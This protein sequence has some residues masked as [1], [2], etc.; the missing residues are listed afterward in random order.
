MYLLVYLVTTLSYSLHLKR[1]VL[2]DVVLL[3][4]LYTLRLLAGGAATSVG[5]SPWLGGFSV[6]LFLS[7]A[8]VKRFSELQDIK[9]AG[10]V[11]SN[12]RGYLLSDSEQMRSFGTSSAYASIVVFSLYI[13][14]GDVARLYS[15][16]QRLWLMTPIMILWL[17]RVWLLAS[18]G[19]LDE[20]P[21]IFALTDR[22]SMLLGLV[23]V[24]VILL[25]AA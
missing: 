16:P 25:A 22:M 11:P 19:E 14:Q 18:R 17:S 20:D 6:F 15:H 7:L 5:I 21:V 13:S 2:L 3:S 24:C 12:G 4:G 8:M 23:A 1:V 9:A 10:Q